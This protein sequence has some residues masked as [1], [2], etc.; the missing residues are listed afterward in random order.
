MT[1]KG[2]VDLM[3]IMLLPLL[4]V[5]LTAPLAASAQTTQHIPLTASQN[6]SGEDLPFS[7]AVW[8]GDTLYVSG[9]LDPDLKTHT[10]TQSQAE[11]VLKDVQAFLQTQGLSLSDVVMMRVYLVGAADRANSGPRMDIQ[12]VRAAERQFFGTKDQ[13]NK[14]ACTTVHVLRSGQSAV[15]VEFDFVA[16]RPKP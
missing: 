14:P 12:G 4:T 9:W 2:Q 5:A 16:V 13:P 7:Q 3:K 1:W 6:P 10:D 15:L 11:G 8:A